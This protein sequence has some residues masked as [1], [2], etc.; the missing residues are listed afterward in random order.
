MKNTYTKLD[1][2]VAIFS[3]LLCIVMLVVN[4]KEVIVDNDNMRGVLVFGFLVIT[5]TYHVVVRAKNQREDN[6]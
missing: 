1:L 6:N 2:F 4:I 3:L 5:S